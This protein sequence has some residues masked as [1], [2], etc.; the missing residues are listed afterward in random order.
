[1]PNAMIDTRQIYSLTDFLR[2]HKVHIAHLKE[3]K[4]PEILTINGR[5]EVVL[6]DAESYQNLIER[7]QLMESMTA[8]RRIIAQDKQ[9]GEALTPEERERRMRVVDELTAETERLGLYR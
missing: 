5:A 7:M 3:T 2:N 8:A 9:E 4:A 1:M 6:M